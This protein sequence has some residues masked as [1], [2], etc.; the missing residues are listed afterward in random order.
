VTLS[1]ISFNLSAKTVRLRNLLLRNVNAPSA[2]L[3]VQVVEAFEGERLGFIALN[4]HD[5]RSTEAIVSIAAAGE[6][7]QN[8][9]AVFR[10]SWFV[11]NKAEAESAVLA[12]PKVGKAYLQSL[13]LERCVFLSNQT[14]V[15]IEPWFSRSLELEEVFVLENE[16]EV[17]LRLRSPLVKTTMTSAVL[18]S[19]KPLLEF[20][21]GPDVARLDFSP[22]SSRA[23]Q[24]LSMQPVD[25]ADLANKDGATGTPLPT[26]DWEKLDFEQAPPKPSE[27]LELLR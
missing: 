12:A 15:G 21:T 7:G 14:K 4:L 23:S 1:G 11:A 24:V 16:L 5:P 26:P 8:A 25:A 22:V 17:W 10:D 9:S 13:R 19:T 18:S 20:V 6:K 2:A 27:L 3:S